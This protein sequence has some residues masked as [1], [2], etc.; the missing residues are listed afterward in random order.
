VRGDRIAAWPTWW[1]EAE[2]A[3]QRPDPRL[4]ATVAAEAPELPADFYAVAVP[5]PAEWPDGD[6]RYVQLS[7]AYDRHAAA[8]RARGW[9]VTG[10]GGSRHLDVATDPARV[11]ALVNGA[12]E[13]AADR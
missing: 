2:L 9:T 5:V 1:A 11:V 8:A 7:P 12:A 6:V 4:R 10:D 13:P 3:A